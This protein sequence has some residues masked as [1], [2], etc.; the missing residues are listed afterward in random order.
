M[1]PAETLTAAAD[2]IER[3]AQA[4]TPGAWHFEPEGGSYDYWD[5]RIWSDNGL[6][7]AES[8][9]MSAATG[10]HIALWSPDVALLVVPILRAEAETARSLERLG[11]PQPTTLLLALAER[12]INQTGDRA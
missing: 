11:L 1:T 3:V 7:V 8:D 2:R 12:I 6:I 10:S 9:H 4:A 5:N